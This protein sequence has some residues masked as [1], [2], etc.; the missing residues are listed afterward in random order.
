[1]MNKKAGKN[2]NRLVSIIR[3]PMCCFGICSRVG[4]VFPLGTRAPDIRCLAASCNVCP[5]AVISVV[6]YLSSN[7]S[8][9]HVNGVFRFNRIS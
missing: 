7:D 6:T 4:K 8:V 1:M 3:F 2:V 9:R 5:F